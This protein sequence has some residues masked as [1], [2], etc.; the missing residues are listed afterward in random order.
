MAGEKIDS[1]KGE[2]INVCSGEETSLHQVLAVMEDISSI[3]I[4]VKE[5]NIR[6]GEQKVYVGDP[7]AAFRLLGWKS[8]ISLAQGL[9]LMYEKVRNP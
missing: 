5:G 1:V 6:P 9:R 3:S 7:S 8:E 4:A 2:I